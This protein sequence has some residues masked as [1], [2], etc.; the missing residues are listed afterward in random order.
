M[1]KEMDSER[2]YASNAKKE[3]QRQYMREYYRKN[4][5]KLLEYHAEWGKNHRLK[6]IWW[7]MR[8]RCRDTGNIYYGAKNIKVCDEWND[9]NEFEKWALNNGYSADLTLDRIDSAKGYNPENCRW[10]SRTVQQR[11]RDFCRTVTFNGETHC[12]SEWCEIT[13]ISIDAMRNRLRRGWSIE[14]ALTQKQALHKK[15][16]KS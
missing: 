12:V 16:D 6:E 10:V 8:T 2:I 4:R 11:N 5:S 9:Y 7:A 13:G 3:N 15:G 1:E 14:R